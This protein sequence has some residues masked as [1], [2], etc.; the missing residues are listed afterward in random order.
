MWNRG[1]GLPLQT[2]GE[3][4]SSVRQ[5]VDDGPQ[6]SDSVQDDDRSALYAALPNGPA[7]ICT[8][9]YDVEGSLVAH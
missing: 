1:Q 8:V 5:S 9:F 6:R 3:D 7:D 2:P 4:A